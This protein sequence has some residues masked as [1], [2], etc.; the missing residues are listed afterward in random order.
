MEEE[1]V[2]YDALDQQE[3]MGEK[4]EKFDDTLVQQEWEGTL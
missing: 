2:F 1:E 4:E 3:W